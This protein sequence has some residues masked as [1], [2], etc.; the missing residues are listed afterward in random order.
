MDSSIYERCPALADLD[1]DER[2][3]IRRLGQEVSYAEGERVIEEGSKG[4]HLF[5]L[6]SGRVQVLKGGRGIA[7]LEPGSVLGEM[8]LFNEDLRTSEAQAVR[9]STLLAIPTAELVAGRL[10]AM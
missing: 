7:Q 2:E 8:A 4:T 10:T 3:A 1:Q 6:L 5:I 9:P